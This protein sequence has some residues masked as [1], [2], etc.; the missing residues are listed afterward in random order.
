M[1]VEP[2][3]SV[4]SEVIRYRRLLL[5]FGEQGLVE[6]ASFVDRLCP[7]YA[8]RLGRTIAESDPCLDVRSHDVAQDGSADDRAVLGQ[9]PDET[10]QERLPDATYRWGEQWL[11][12]TILITSRAIIFFCGAGP[13]ASQP[14]R[15]TAGR[16]ASVALGPDDPTLG[17][18]TAVLVLTDGSRL[19]F[20]F[21]AVSDG[22]PQ[23]AGAFGRERTARFIDSIRWL[24]APAR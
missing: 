20:G 24:Q 4:S 16:I 2:T 19:V 14:P 9:E 11:A 7:S 18:P 6:S 8:L 1:Y 17:G 13:C 5:R 21:R 23:A 12:G 3:T 22:M 15:L 10:I